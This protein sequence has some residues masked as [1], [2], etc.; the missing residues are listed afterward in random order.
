MARLPRRTVG[1]PI[2]RRLPQSRHFS[3]LFEAA[4][5]STA[6]L[7]FVPARGLTR[8]V[9]LC[10]RREVIVKNPVSHGSENAEQQNGPGS[11]HGGLLSTRN[12]VSPRRDRVSRLVP[13]AC[14]REMW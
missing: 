1:L 13:E 4:N 3:A 5:F 8:F 9:P 2:V 11:S 14:I 10:V 12:A 6:S 7:S